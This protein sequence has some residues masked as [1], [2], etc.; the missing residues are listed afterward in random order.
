MNTSIIDP[1]VTPYSSADEIRAWI[2]EL[3]SMPDSEAKT[4]ELRLARSWLVNRE[5]DAA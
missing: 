1:P 3:E 4:D 2:S 5:G